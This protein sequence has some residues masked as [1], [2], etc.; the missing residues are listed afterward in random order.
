[1]KDITRFIQTELNPR[2][3]AHIPQIFPELHFTKKGAKY[4]SSYHPEERKRTGA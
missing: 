3:Y 1:M 2:I 4:V